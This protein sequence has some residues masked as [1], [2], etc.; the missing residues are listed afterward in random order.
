MFSIVFRD[1]RTSRTPEYRYIDDT[2]TVVKGGKSRII[3][4][5]SVFAFSRW[6]MAFSKRVSR[7]RTKPAF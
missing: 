7:R 2:S 6:W 4:R 5:G 3:K 1:K